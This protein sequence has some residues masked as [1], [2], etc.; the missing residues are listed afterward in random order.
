MNDQ[1]QIIASTV[2]ENHEQAPSQVPELL[3]Q[4]EGEIERFIGGGIYDQDAIYTAVK[5]HS[6]GASVIIPPSKD[7]VLS[8]TASTSPT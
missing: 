2:T 5:N 7:A 4:V 8:P 6:P 3:S 1:G